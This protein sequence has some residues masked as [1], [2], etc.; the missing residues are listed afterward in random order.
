MSARV[1]DQLPISLTIV[2]YPNRSLS[3][4]GF[5]LLMAVIVV[6]SAAVGGFFLA[7]GA[8]PVTGFFGLDVLLIYWA[9]KQNYRQ[10]RLTEYLKLD[11]DCFLV[12]RVQPNG[13]VEEWTFEPYWAR[14]LI[15]EPLAHDSRLRIVSHGREVQ[16]GA[17]LAPEERLDLANELRATL[18]RLRDPLGSAETP[19]G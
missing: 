19:S 15:D 5:F 7:I 9:F 12:R 6:V 18:A 14:V 8:W 11:Q 16:V 13:K 17:F 4:N 2:L 1:A 10:G 3:S